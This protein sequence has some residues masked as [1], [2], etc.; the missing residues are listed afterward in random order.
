MKKRYA[1]V[2]AGTRCLSMFVERLYKD[3]KDTVEFVG[4]Y[5]I[6]KLRSKYFQNKLNGKL[7]IYYDFEQMLDEAKPDAVFVTSVD[8]NHHEYII[9]ALEKGCDVLSEKPITNTYERC[10]AIRE[11]EKKSN[12]NVITTFNCRFMPYFLEIKKIIKSGKIGKVLHV[13]LDHFLDRVHGGSYFTRWHRMMENSQGML[14]HKSTHDFDVVNWFLEDEPKKVTAVANRVFYGDKDKCFA[15]RCSQCSKPDCESR[16]GTE[17][18]FKEFYIDCESEDGYIAD[19]CAFKPDTDICDNYSVSVEY[20]GGAI[21]SYSL[22]LFSFDEG[23]RFTITGEKGMI[24]FYI[25][26]RAEGEE[27]D[28]TIINILF[29]NGKSEQIKQPRNQHMHGGGDERLIEMLFSGKDY[30]DEY[31]QCAG[32]FDGFASA[33][34]GIGANESMQ[35]GKIVDLTEKLNKLR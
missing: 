19:T 28:Y 18:F 2:G 6:N 17:G 16:I 24:N 15:E 8:S 14:L 31:N 1:I 23:H 5:D 9:R 29:A 10:L 26:K 32:S 22:N 3:Y 33:M 4:V 13:S 11:A 35:T 7:T 12:K 20:N 25:G 30:D 21:L 27:K 34:I